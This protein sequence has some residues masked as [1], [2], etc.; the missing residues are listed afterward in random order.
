LFIGIEK[1]ELLTAP[2][3]RGAPKQSAPGV[4]AGENCVTQSAVTLGREALQDPRAR[5]S[6]RL[7]RAE[8]FSAGEAV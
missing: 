7:E 8:I 1:G 6:M 5:P 3:R 4:E 2:R